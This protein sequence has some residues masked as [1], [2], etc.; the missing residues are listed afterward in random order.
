[1]AASVNG[2]EL[3]LDILLQITRDGNIVILPL[4]IFLINISILIRKERAFITKW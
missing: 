4:R 3:V 1:M 2:R